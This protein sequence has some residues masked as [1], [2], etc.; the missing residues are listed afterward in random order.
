MITITYNGSLNSVKEAVTAANQ[1][2]N[3]S[4]FY[5]DIRIHPNFDYTDVSPSIIA[6]LIE[7]RI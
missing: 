1:L 4:Q 7:I 6:D 5:D 2:L 3:N